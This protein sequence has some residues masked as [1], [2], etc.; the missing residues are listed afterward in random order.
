MD[1]LPDNQQEL[2][3]S[4]LHQ[5]LKESIAAEEF[6]ERASG[7]IVVEILTKE[8][9]RLTRLIASD[10]FLKDHMGY[11][12]AVCELRANQG[13]LMRLH[14]AASPARKAKIQERLDEK[15]NV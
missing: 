6:F 3:V 2:E 5:Q 11:V 12:T 4:Q 7:K 1:N 15:E 8:I 9:T 14:V 13:L 10:K